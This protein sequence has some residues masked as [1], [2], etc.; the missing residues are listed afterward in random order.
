VVLVVDAVVVVVALVV[1]VVVAR[2]VVVVARAV[3]VVARAVVVV[4]P[5]AVVVVV[6]RA[7]VVVVAVCPNALAMADI[8]VAVSLMLFIWLTL[9]SALVMVDADFPF[10]CDDA[11]APWQPAQFWV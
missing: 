9:E 6:G 11:S 5:A 8:C 3:V 1:V 7:V 10:I 4:V 2:A